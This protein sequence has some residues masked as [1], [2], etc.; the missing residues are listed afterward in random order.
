MRRLFEFA[1]R[2]FVAI[3]ALGLCVAFGTFVSWVIGGFLFRER[4]ISD[5]TLFAFPLYGAVPGLVLGGVCYAVILIGAGDAKW[6]GIRRKT[7]L[8]NNP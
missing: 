7:R 5:A 8:R 2:F 6:L 1:L 4:L 3:L